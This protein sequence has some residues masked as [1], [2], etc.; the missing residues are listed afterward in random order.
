MQLR[1]SALVC[2]LAVL[3]TSAGAQPADSFPDLMD[4]IELRKD[5]EVIYAGRDE[6]VRGR[7]VAVSPSS[8]IV[9]AG[10]APLELDAERVL[11]VR[12]R[13]Q[14]PTRDGGLKGFAVGVGAYAVLYMLERYWEGEGLSTPFVGG[15]IFGLG[16]YLIG[17]TI[18]AGKR[19]NRAIY[20]APA[21]RPRAAV[22]PLLSKE[23]AGAA[24]SITW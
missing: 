18:D 4:R 6:I 21:R 24:L 3:P 9:L 19:E 20:R 7:A 8:L 14:D 23:R 1:F 11:R 22:S 17:I 10:G 13:W 5:V 16:G 12:Q 15:G 2:A